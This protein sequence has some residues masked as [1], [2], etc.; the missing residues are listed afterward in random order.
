M[1]EF[2][3]PAL[4]NYQIGTNHKQERNVG[5]VPNVANSECLA[6]I[7]II[8]SADSGS[9]TTTS[10]RWGENLSSYLFVATNFT[11]LK[12]FYF[13]ADFEKKIEP[14]DNKFYYF[15]PNKIVNAKHSTY[16]AD[17]TNYICLPWKNRGLE[18]HPNLQLSDLN[19][20]QSVNRVNIKWGSSQVLTCA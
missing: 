2:E 4:T 7:L 12:L 6:R 14:N 20:R 19:T 11:T 1:A 10:K 16:L 5:T 17:R 3:I 18:E 15:L 9:R 13:W 8:S